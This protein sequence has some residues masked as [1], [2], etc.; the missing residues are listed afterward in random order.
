MVGEIGA[1]RI[2]PRAPTPEFE[3]DVVRRAARG[4]CLWKVRYG[5]RSTRAARISPDDVRIRQ[6]VTASLHPLEGFHPTLASLACARPHAPDVGLRRK[7]FGAGSG[8]KLIP[9]KGGQI[10]HRPGPLSNPVPS[11]VAGEI[12]GRSGG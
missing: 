11:S 10:R 7:L 6:A 4:L 2:A 8:T 5:W 12:R 3:D 1:S 9:S